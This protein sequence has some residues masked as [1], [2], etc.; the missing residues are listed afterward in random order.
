MKVYSLRNNLKFELCFYLI[1]IKSYDHFSVTGMA[2]LIHHMPTQYQVCS[3]C[4]QFLAY[5][6]K[7]VQD[8]SGFVLS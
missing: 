3:I 4:V 5:V 7:L 2:T 8:L 6:C 1:L